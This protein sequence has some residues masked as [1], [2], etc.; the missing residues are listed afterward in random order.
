MLIG[1]KHHLASVDMEKVNKWTSEQ[2]KSLRQPLFTSSQYFTIYLGSP[3]FHWPAK[4]GMW[5]P[6]LSSQA[7]QLHFRLFLF[8]TKLQLQLQYVTN[9]PFV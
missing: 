7:S 4:R 6:V 5:T 3:G 8:I 2:V 9:V 1:N